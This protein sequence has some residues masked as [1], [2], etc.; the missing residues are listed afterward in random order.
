MAKT[1]NHHIPAAAAAAAAV[2]KHTA[3]PTVA[4]GSSNICV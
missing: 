4:T 2:H 3:E 1:Y